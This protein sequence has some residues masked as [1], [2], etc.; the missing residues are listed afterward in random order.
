MQSSTTW[1]N[2]LSKFWFSPKW[3]SCF[4][5]KKWGTALLKS[6][7]VITYLLSHTILSYAISY[8]SLWLPTG[9]RW[10]LKVLLSV[11]KIH[12]WYKND[13]TSSCLPVLSGVQG[14]QWVACRAGGLCA[15]DREGRGPVWG[16]IWRARPWI[17]YSGWISWTEWRELRGLEFVC[18]MFPRQ[19]LPV[20][21]SLCWRLTPGVCSDTK[22]QLE[23]Q[24]VCAL[25]HFFMCPFKF[26][27]LISQRKYGDY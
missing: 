18:S 2:P 14:I 6:S 5:K 1:R 20:C 10:E 16:M 25:I 26:L 19:G 13:K 12:S 15:H 8:K 24:L 3:S 11:W 21:L 7:F 4:G 27:A 23:F 17:K 9:K 22:L